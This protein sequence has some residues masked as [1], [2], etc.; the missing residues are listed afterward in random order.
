MEKKATNSTPSIIIDEKKG[1]MKLEGVSFHEDISEI[2][3]EAVEWLEK[4]IVSDFSSFI[5]DCKLKYFN[6]TTSKI[7]FSILDKLNKA[8]DGKEITV[9]WHVNQADDL[10]VEL[11]D[12]IKDEYKKL[13]V[14]LIKAT[15]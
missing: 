11:C 14:N 4:Y 10:M 6:S 1:Y 2:F 3:R 8:A 5:F 7:L 9:N 15:F 13:K 12:D